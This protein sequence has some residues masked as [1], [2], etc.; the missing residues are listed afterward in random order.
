MA[1][2]P[3]QYL[4]FAKER[5]QPCTDLISRLN[6]DFGTILDLG[7]G[8]G[9]S[10]QNL[11]SKFGGA[12]IVGFDADDEMLRRARAEHPDFEFVKGFAPD[13]LSEL[14]KKFDL[15]FSNA[16]IH[17]IENQEKLADTVYEILNDGG[18]FAAQTPIQ[19]KSKFYNILHR[20]VDE[21]YPA[22]KTV[23]NFHALTA[24]GYYNLLTKRFSDVTIWQS[25][26][27]HVVGKEA[28]LEWFKGSGLRPYLARLDGE[29]QQAFTSDLQAEIDKEFAPLADGNVFL[30][31]P[32]LFLVAKK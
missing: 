14:N 20:L 28:V 31:M 25:D 23:D 1:W 12:S 8:P 32:R 11:S 17:W 24:D 27:Y 3:E 15:V 2:N 29:E 19:G 5:N 30:V 21:K 26:Y 16:C 9:N 10:T 6:G 7:C 18:I 22:L 4:K 13:G